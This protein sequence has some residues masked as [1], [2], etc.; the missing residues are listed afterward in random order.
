MI[1]SGGL[2]VVAPVVGWWMPEGVSTHAHL[3]DGLFY[4]ILAVTGFFFV[5]TE[6][7]LCVFMSKYSGDRAPASESATGPGLAAKLFRPVTMILNDPHKVEMA[8]T[9]VPAVI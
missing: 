3:V 1:L 5:L 8:W 9:I 7:I 6:A 2:F 4:W